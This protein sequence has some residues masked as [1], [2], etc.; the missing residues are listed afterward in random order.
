M[1]D[2]YRAVAPDVKLG[3]D[4]RLARFVNLYGCEIGDETKIGAFVEI[5][6]NAKV[7]RRCKISSHTFICEGVTIEDHVFIGHGVTFINDSTRARRPPTGELQTE[8]DWKVEP[9]LVKKGAS[10][11]SGATILCR[12]SPSARAPSS[13]PAAWSRATCR[14]CTIVGATRR[15]VLLRRDRGDDRE[16]TQVSQTLR[17]G[18][19][20]VR[21][22]GSEHR[23]EPL[24]RSTGARW[25]RSATRARRRS[26]RRA[27]STRACSMTTDPCEVLASPDIDAVAIVTPVWT[28]FE[29]AKAAL[30][31]GKH[32][33]VEKPFTAT[34]Q[35]AEELIELADRKNLRIMVDHTFLFTGR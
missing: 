13:A 18:V 29:L 7:G 1:M 28:H 15:R 11:G 6:K 22:L 2:D 24:R 30:E 16:V 34:S 26:R 25:R 19:D 10:I 31:N 17:V 21:L 32:V 8:Q 23:Q 27:A 3:K 9:T 35:Q 4:V 33:F 20:R 12:T 5:Q 14:P